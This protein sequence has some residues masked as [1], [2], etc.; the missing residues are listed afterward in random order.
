[1][2]LLKL[3]Q[4]KKSP[5]RWYAELESGESLRVGLSEIAAL[6]LYA[7]REL[8]E[9]ETEKLRAGSANFSAKER[10]L[11]LLSSRQ[12]SRKELEKK[13]REKG[14]AEEDIASAADLME[15]IGALND[16]EYAAAIVRHYSKR[17]Y[18]KGRITQELFRRGVEKELWEEALSELP[19]E[20]DAI[21]VLISRRL[22]GRAPEGEEKKK[23]CDM[24]LRRGYSWTEIKEALNR[25]G[26][27]TEEIEEYE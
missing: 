26:A 14:A 7:G 11:R 5:D 10:S 3:V 17:G 18:G 16:N 25:Y 13:L 19:V 4:S 6:S 27:N 24:L 22:K 21:D 8:S 20:T 12:M 23:L 9:E 2:K 15:R 1:M